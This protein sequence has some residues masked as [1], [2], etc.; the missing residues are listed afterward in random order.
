[1]SG[2]IQFYDA[3]Q[4]LA[5]VGPGR[6]V[7]LVRLMELDEANRY[8]ARPVEF[9]ADGATVLACDRQITV[10]NLAEPADAPGQI[11]TQTDAVALD[12]EGRWV[13]FI[14]PVG[15]ACFPA[16]IVQSLGGAAYTI[17][18]QVATGPG[19]FAD[20]QDTASLTAYNLAEL[21]LGAGGAVDDDTIVL[22][23]TVTQDASPPVLRYVFDHPTYAKYLD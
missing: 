15:S 19:T 9:D 13:T 18:E 4:R 14:R 23:T 11:P 20:R 5:Q 7:Q 1:M 3:L 6:G 16:R 10:T 2:Q 12:V 22:A 17:I 8:N 21:S